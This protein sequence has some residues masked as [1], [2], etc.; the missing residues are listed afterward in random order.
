MALEEWLVRNGIDISSEVSAFLKA[1]DNASW[2]AQ[3]DNVLEG[4]RHVDLLIGFYHLVFFGEPPRIV[5]DYYD[6]NPRV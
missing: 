3:W 1:C 5:H 6:L 4:R 2:T